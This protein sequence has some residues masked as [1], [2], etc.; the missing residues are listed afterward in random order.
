[1]QQH[2]TIYPYASSV[3]KEKGQCQPW[4]STPHDGK[5]QLLVIFDPI[6][7]QDAWHYSFQS[8]AEHKA[9]VIKCTPTGALAEHSWGILE[10]YCHSIFKLFKLATSQGAAHS[11]SVTFPS[12]TQAWKPWTSSPNHGTQCQTSTANSI[13]EDPN[14][15]ESLIGTSYFQETY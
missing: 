6:L 2:P 13:V 7:A 14:R 11:Y 5:C 12:I 8:F 1:M 4:P 3:S 9:A 15:L 10:H